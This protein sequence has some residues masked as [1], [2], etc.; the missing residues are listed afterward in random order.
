[1]VT[2]V[3]TG[4]VL[5]DNFERV[6]GDATEQMKQTFHTYEARQPA[7]LPHRSPLAPPWSRRAAAL[8]M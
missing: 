4:A 2:R 6:N 7:V 3:K 8:K 1:M 5:G